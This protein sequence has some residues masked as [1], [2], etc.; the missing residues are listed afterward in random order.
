M[1]AAGAGYSARLLARD[2]E[3]AS[4]AA[5]RA[6][7]WN[8]KA[9]AWESDGYVRTTGQRADTAGFFLSSDRAGST[10]TCSRAPYSRVARP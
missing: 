9:A 10:S 6:F 3:L 4:S 8:L 5:S 2:T 1:E 7:C